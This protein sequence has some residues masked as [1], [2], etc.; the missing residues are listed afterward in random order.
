M[1]TNLNLAHGVAGR[2]V[3]LG[4]LLLRRR[5]IESLIAPWAGREGPRG[6]L[7]IRDYYAAKVAGN[8]GRTLPYITNNSW[9]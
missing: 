4:L 7:T 3:C 6:R 9:P 1:K 5:H 8:S 2:T